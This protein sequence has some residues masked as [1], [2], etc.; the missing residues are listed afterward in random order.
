MWSSVAQWL[1][2]T[3]PT[4]EGATGR[5]DLSDGGSHVNHEQLLPQDLFFGAPAATGVDLTHR[6]HPR[7]HNSPR[8]ADSW[9]SMMIE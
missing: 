6:L 7:Q 4:T 1:T 9:A 8:I 2:E 5:I 3:L